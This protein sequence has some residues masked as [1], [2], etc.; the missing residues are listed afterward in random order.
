MSTQLKNLKRDSRFLT[1]EQFVARYQVSKDFLYR[2]TQQNST[3]PIP[4]LKMGKLIRIDIESPAFKD[5]ERRHFR[6][7]TDDGSDD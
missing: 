4:H 3:D 5:W 7:L 2:R 1:P 6:N